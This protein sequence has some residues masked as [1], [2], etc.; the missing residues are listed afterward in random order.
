MEKLMDDLLAAFDA[1]DMEETNRLM[2]KFL[3]AVE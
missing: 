3:Q 1:G 2:E